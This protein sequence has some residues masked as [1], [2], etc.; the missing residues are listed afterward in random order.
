MVTNLNVRVKTI[1]HLEKN[2]VSML[3]EVGYDADLLKITTKAQ[4]TKAKIN[5]LHQNLK[6]MHHRKLS[7]KMAV[8]RMVNSIWKSL[9]WQKMSM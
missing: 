8:H 9:I 6:Y 3:Y 4:A 2:T 5:W 7:R 1:K